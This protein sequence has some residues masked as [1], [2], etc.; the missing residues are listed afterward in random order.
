MALAIDSIQ[1]LLTIEPASEADGRRLISLYL[2]T[3]NRNEALRICLQLEQAVRA[4]LGVELE[5]ATLRLY[6]KAT[7]QK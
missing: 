7:N 5:E 4:E 3:G 1:Q 2:E 6:D